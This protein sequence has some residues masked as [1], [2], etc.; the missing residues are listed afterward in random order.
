MSKHY[1]IWNTHY[2]VGGQ[3]CKSPADALLG[4]CRVEGVGDEAEGSRSGGSVLTAA[5]GKKRNNE[6]NIVRMAKGCDC[7]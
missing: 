5:T 6:R 4:T 3:S 1:V 2:G 7:T